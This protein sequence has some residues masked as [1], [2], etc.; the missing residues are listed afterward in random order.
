MRNGRHTINTLLPLL[1]TPNF[2][3]ANPYILLQLL[4]FLVPGKLYPLVD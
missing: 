3:V 2:A 4:M 1:L